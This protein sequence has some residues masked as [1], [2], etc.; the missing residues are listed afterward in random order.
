[1]AEINI[2]DKEQPFIDNCDCGL[3]CGCK[4]CNSITCGDNY[5]TFVDDL[6]KCQC[7]LR[8]RS[9]VIILKK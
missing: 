4:K 9:E 5:H 6:H 2:G 7:G 8:D 1:M 3:T